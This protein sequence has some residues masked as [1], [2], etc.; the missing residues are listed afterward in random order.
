MSHVAVRFARDTDIYKC[1]SE[2]YKCSHKIN[3]TSFYGCSNFLNF[4]TNGTP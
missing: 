1:Q 2:I 4:D 3:N